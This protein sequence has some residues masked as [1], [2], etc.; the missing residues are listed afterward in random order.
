MK[1]DLL[2]R[3]YKIASLA[4]LLAL[5]VYGQDKKASIDIY[6]VKLP[7]N[8]KIDKNIS[9]KYSMT[10]EYF[11]RG[12]D[13]NFMNKTKVIGDYT[14]GLEDGNVQWN[15]VYIAQADSLKKAFPNGTMQN[16]MENMKN[17]PSGKN[18]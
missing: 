3:P 15:N 9:Q 5:N 4:I 13:G 8:I 17:I 14:C 2:G 18:A 12:I 11:T 10:A 1:I 16:Y 6:L 7:H